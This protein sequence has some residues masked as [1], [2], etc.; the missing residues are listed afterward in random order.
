[1]IEDGAMDLSALHQALAV[2]PGNVPLLL[3]VAKLEEDQFAMP[4]ARA[5]LDRVLAIEPGN[6]EA[7]LGIARLLDFTGESSEA[8]VRLEDLCAREP[9]YGAAWLLR[10][11][12][13]LEEGEAA[14]AREYYDRAVGLDRALA[15]DGLLE[16]ILKARGVNRAVQTTDGGI[17]E[18]E[19]EEEDEVGGMDAVAALEL[20]VEFRVRTEVRFGDVG[21]M[22]GVKDDI[23]MKIVHPLRNPELFAAYGKKAGG[24]VLLYGP[25]GCGKTLMAQ[26]TAGEIEA[27]FLSVG[28]HQI[29][30]M[31]IGESEQKLHGIFELARRS[32]PAVLFFDETDALAADRRDMRQSAGR[33]LVNQFLSE[34]D[35]LQ[36]SNEGLLV[37]GATNAPWQLDGAFL[38]PGR[39]DRVIFVPPPD[40]GARVE[41]AKIHARGKPLTGFDAEDIAKRTEGFSGADL[42]AVFDRATEEALGEA[43]RKGGMVPVTGKM[44]AKAAKEVK[45]STR[46]WFESA[47]NHALYANQGGIYDDIL[48]YLGLKK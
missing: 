13:A 47:K 3:M 2:S 30:D 9:G 1:M 38:R 14:R 6:R 10:A 7:L 43:M 37:L 25:P 35:G 8:M 46:K 5:L 22:D 26:A 19:D 4:A 12:L 16:E 39:F 40:F 34:L 42:K 18:G 48:E 41:I 33:T 17:H 29:L 28:L 31:Y 21:G 15:D 23:R 27:S 45:P 44:L 20:G 36:A 32:R 24:G 11:R